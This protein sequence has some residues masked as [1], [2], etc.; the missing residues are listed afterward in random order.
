MVG[1]TILAINLVI[2]IGIVLGLIIVLDIDP[3]VSL[4]SGSLYMGIASGLGLTETVDAIGEGFGDL[5]A[6]IGLPIIFG[7]M[8][9]MLLARCGGA[10]TIALG[11]TDAVPTKYIPYAIGISGA[12]IAIPVFF[13]VAF[14]VMIPMVIALWRET[15]LSYPLVIGPLA[16]GAAGA[17]TFIPPTPNP[18]AAPALLDFELGTMMIVGL[19]GG[20]LSI[21]L[22]IGVFVAVIDHIWTGDDISEIPFVDEEEETVENPPSFL[23]SLLPIAVPII[24]IMIGTTSEALLGELNVFFEFLS[25]QIIALLAGLIVA[26]IIYVITM[27]HENLSDEFS[28]ALRPAGIVLAITG[29]G[30]AFGFVIQETEAA[31]AMLSLVGASGDGIMIVVIAYVLGL[32]MRVAQGS[33]TVAGITAMTIIAGVE[34]TVA[35]VA[36]AL[37]ALAG[38]MSIGHINDSGFWVVTELAG[39]EVTGGLKTYTLGGAIVSIFAFFFSI[40]IALIL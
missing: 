14:L 4:V 28:E 32:V 30:G 18:L 22:S 29:A 19:I 17:H 2:A 38:G 9:G 36:L 13:D 10:R 31:D 40:V 20:I 33:G 8:I 15:E 6:S 7:I 34:T 12:I 35:P 16:I 3:A 21:T 1:T 27:G 11:M 37:S 25:S 23:V 5:M 24:F 26:I 39:L